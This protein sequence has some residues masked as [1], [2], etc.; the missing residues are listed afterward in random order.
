MKQCAPRLAVLEFV[1]NFERFEQAKSIDNIVD[2]ME[3]STVEVRIKDSDFNQLCADGASNAKGS[4]AEYEALARTRRS[5]NV[6]V[7]VCIS[8]QNQRSAGYASGTVDFAKPVNEELGGIIR[9]SHDITVHISRAPLRMSVY[10]DVQKRRKRRPQLTFK[11]GNDTRWD[12]WLLETQRNNMIM[13]DICAT[14][15]DLRCSGGLDEKLASQ[16]A[17]SLSY[18][19]EDKTILRQFEAA[20][21]NATRLSKFTQDNNNAWA[22]LLFKIKYT[23]QESRLGC[24][25][26][27]GGKCL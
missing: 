3:E 22:Y 17:K 13:G 18:T 10:N 7:D 16:D 4:I 2:W 24:F 11:V 21:W 15:R 5:N 20:A 14:L 27:H 6:D 19:T 23:L 9:K 1:G 12:S 8:H 25:L 26:M